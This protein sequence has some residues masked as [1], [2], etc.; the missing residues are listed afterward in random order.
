M[1]SMVLRDEIRDWVLIHGRAQRAAAK[2]FGVS[3]NTVAALRREP[4]ESGARRYTRRQAR[5]APVREQVLPYRAG[6]PLYRRLVAGERPPA[7]LGTQAAL[8]GAP[9]VGRAAEP[10]QR[11]R[12][13]DGAPARA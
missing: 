12:R 9:E 5:D 10:G 1:Y 6:A 4:A 13:V 8:D 2:H 11:G 7:A 3:R